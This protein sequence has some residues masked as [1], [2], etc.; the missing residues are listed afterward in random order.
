MRIFVTG[1]AGFIG[2][3]FVLKQVLQENNE[4]LNYDESHNL[5]GGILEKARGMTF[6]KGF[7]PNFRDSEAAQRQREED[8]NVKHIGGDAIEQAKAVEVAKAIEIANAIFARFKLS[9]TNAHWHLVYNCFNLD[10]PFTSSIAP[11]SPILFKF[12]Y[13]N[14]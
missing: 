12:Y 7:V 9:T 8:K 2:G 5:T 6:N 10:K 4:V 11:I 14:N 13:E 3:N 1:G